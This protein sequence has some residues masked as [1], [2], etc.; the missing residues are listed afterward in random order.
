[1]K[2]IVRNNIWKIF[3]IIGILGFGLVGF[4]GCNIEGNLHGNQTVVLDLE[5]AFGGAKDVNLSDI[6][7]VNLTVSGPDMDT[8]TETYDP[9]TLSSANWAI[10]VT[11]PPGD[12]RKFEIAADVSGST[13]AILRYYGSSTQTIDEDH[14]TVDVYMGVSKM[15]IIT[16]NPAFDFNTQGASPSI[17]VMDDMNGSNWIRITDSD[18][19]W[20]GTFVPWDMDIDQYGN[21][22]LVNNDTGT[23]AL[24]KITSFSPV[25]YTSVQ[26]GSAPFISVAVDRQNSKVYYAS[27]TALYSCNYDGTGVKALAG[28]FGSIT[29]IAFDNGILYLV[30]D[31][32]TNKLQKYNVTT[33]TLI[34]DSG[35][36]SSTSL[37]DI[38]VK[39]DYIYVADTANKQIVKLNKSDLS[40]VATYNAD[41]TLYG[42]KRFVATLNSGIYFVDES[43][44]ANDDRLIYIDDINGNG[45]KSFGSYGYGTGQFSFYYV[46]PGG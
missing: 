9:D 35:S 44:S 41:G 16:M 25:T 42:P 45:Y 20:A 6:S 30:D 27:A 8:I 43:D 3:L 46:V 34:E 18:L 28:T 17:T 11:V 22:W 29:G 15:K 10:S 14:S 19:G 26:S 4:S 37:N 23:P 36:I 21:V 13:N 40:V 38:M 39:G 33:E 7:S 32:A 12:D 31:G 2:T 1:M 24:I 5:E